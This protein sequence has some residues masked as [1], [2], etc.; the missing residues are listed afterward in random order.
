MNLKSIMWNKNSLFKS[1]RHM[2]LYIYV[3]THDCL[4]NIFLIKFLK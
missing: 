3:I 4:H 2:I 1:D